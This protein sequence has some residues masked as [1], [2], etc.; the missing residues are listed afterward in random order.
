MLPVACQNP[1]A[2]VAN[3]A[4]ITNIHLKSANLGLFIVSGPLLRS[5]V[6]AV[7]CL[8]Y[9]IYIFPLNLP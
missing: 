8:F 7:T 1:T 4:I 3:T 5:G 2:T 6:Q 9:R